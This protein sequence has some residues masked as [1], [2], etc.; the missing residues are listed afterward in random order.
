M[1][2]VLSVLLIA[3]LVLT[4]LS[5]TG[6]LLFRHFVAD[7]ITDKGGMMN[8]DYNDGTE[9]VPVLDGDHTYVDNEKLLQVIIGTWSSEDGH[10]VIKLD[11]EYRI[12]LSLDGELLLD[13]HTADIIAHSEDYKTGDPYLQVEEY[14][15][16][17]DAAKAVLESGNPYGSYDGEKEL[18]N[19]TWY[20]AE[21]AAVAQIGEKV[22]MVKGYKCDFGSDEVQGILGSL[23]WVK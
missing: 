14:P 2:K 5:V 18:T 1:K 13:E 23:Q 22:F 6:V 8:P 9:P 10:Y 3:L 11:G 19:G 12:V 17:L 15:Q 4:V 7:Q 21:N 20:L 16:N